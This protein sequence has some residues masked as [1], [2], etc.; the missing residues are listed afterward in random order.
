ML[1]K[2]NDQNISL[3]SNHAHGVVLCL[4]TSGGLNEIREL[5]KRDVSDLCVLSYYCCVV[6]ADNFLQYSVKSESEEVK[7]VPIGWQVKE[8]VFW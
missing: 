2:Q 1:E 5:Y 7:L 4:S 3:P 8:S 6:S